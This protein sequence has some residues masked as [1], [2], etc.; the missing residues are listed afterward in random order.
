MKNSSPYDMDI[1]NCL[2]IARNLQQ[3]GMTIQF[4]KSF[5]LMNGVIGKIFGNLDKMT[6]NQLI[7][8]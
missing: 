2:Q 7:E 3:L 1:I 5:P 4:S 8:T 6:T